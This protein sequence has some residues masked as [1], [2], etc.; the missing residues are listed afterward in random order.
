[1]RPITDFIARRVSLA[2]SAVAA[3]ALLFSG[4]PAAAQPPAGQ[5]TPPAQSAQQ[6]AVAQAN[7]DLILTLI[8]SSLVAVQQADVTGNY[9]VLRQLGSPSFQAANDVDK[10]SA[11]FSGIRKSNVDLSGAVVLYPQIS[12]AEL[13][14]TV[15]LHVSGTFATK[16]VPVRFEFLFQPIQGHWTIDGILIAPVTPTP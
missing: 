5:Q 4:S 7:A 13:T 3:I 15:M 9:S 6:G 1:M 14:N 12:K 2:S 16:P 10:L 8:R 11:T